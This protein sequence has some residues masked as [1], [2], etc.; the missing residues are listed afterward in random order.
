[1]HASFIFST[2]LIW[3]DSLSSSLKYFVLFIMFENWSFLSRRYLLACM[4]YRV[5]ARASDTHRN[6]SCDATRKRVVSL[7]VHFAGAKCTGQMR[8]TRVRIRPSVP[9]LYYQTM[10]LPIG[11]AGSEFSRRASLQRA[12]GS[13]VSV[14]FGTSIWSDAFRRMTRRGTRSS[15]IW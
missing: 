4:F 9:S 7:I 10:Q 12:L 15:W 11:S 3:I 8:Q 2:D 13:S 14:F 5:Y 1:M 6:F